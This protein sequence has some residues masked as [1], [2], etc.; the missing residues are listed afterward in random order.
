MTAQ[1]AAPKSASNLGLLSLVLLLGVSV[2]IHTAALI[3]SWGGEALQTLLGNTL[4]LPVNL[5]CFAIMLWVSRRHQGAM[6][7]AWAWMAMAFLAY[8]VGDLVWAYLELVLQAEPF[9]SVADLFYILFPIG[10]GIGLW[11]L[12]KTRLSRLE[13][14]KLAL[15]VLVVVAAVGVFSW[16]AFLAQTVQ[17]YGQ[18]WLTLGVSLFYPTADLVLLALLLLIAF[19]QQFS[20]AYQVGLGLGLSLLIFADITFN[21]QSATES[22]VTGTPLDSLWSW[23]NFCFGLAAYSSLQNQPTRWSQTLQFAAAR[24]HNLTFFAPYGAI[25]LTFV[26]AIRNSS[27]EGLVEAGTLVGVAVVTLLV[28]ARQAVAFSE[29]R[30][31]TAQLQRFN[32]ELEG[33]VAERTRELEDNRERLLA[34]EKLAALG[35]LTAGI[36]HEINTP[37]AGSMN[38]LLQARK[39]GQEYHDS[40]GQP[41]VSEA[42]HRE[43]AGELLGA[44]ENTNTSLERMGEFIRRMRTQGRN[45]QGTTS[46]FNPV[47]T[48]RE[49]L[50]M[51][52]PQAQQAGVQ[53]EL[54]VPE[55][56][57]ILPGEAGRFSQILNNLVQNGIHACED[58]RDPKGSKVVIELRPQATGLEVRVCDN[59]SGIPAEVLPKIFEPLFTT[60]AVGKGTGLGLPII[61]DIVKGHFAG[62]ITL[63]TQQGQG[64]TF[65]LKL[66]LQQHQA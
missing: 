45:P 50:T 32:Q 25:L 38:Y 64:T 12:P 16:Q 27:V 65:V 63:Q 49:T 57:P 56:I 37:L 26:L 51:L 47:K 5:L 15:D 8:T 18:D 20:G 41:Q 36:A 35:R 2:L 33:R 34:S 42:D 48:A 14:L 44:L 10:L 46:S 53:L 29:N 24:F 43:I 59:G 17:D 60:K 54:Q 52:E 7:R 62:E 19:R 21:V 55:S 23:A 58:R 28:V 31:L 3:F 4:N 11:Q 6:R 40:I 22:Y 61:R 1:V 30:H 13:N 39:L 9:P 66:P